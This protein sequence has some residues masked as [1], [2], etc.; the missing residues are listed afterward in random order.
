M[1]MITIFIYE[2][3]MAEGKH[4]ASA[5]VNCIDIAPFQS[6]SIQNVQRE[7]E[8]LDSKLLKSGRLIVHK[9]VFI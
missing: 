8:Y 2:H 9:L 6:L 1:L 5:I 7:I 4:G 3:I